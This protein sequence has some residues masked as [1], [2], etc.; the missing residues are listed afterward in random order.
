MNWPAMRMGF[1]IQDKAQLAAIRPGDRVQF[2][3]H[4]KPDQDGNYVIA[5]I[6]K[7]R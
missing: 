2:D 5:R 1:L 4:A 7:G 6:E 3:L